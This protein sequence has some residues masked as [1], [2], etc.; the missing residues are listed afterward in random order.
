MYNV[1]WP[2]RECVMEDCSRPTVSSNVIALMLSEHRIASLST[3]LLSSAIELRADRMT[4]MSH[5]LIWTARRL[6]RFNGEPYKHQQRWVD[7]VTSWLAPVD[8]VD[9]FGVG[10]KFKRSEPPRTEPCGTQVNLLLMMSVCCSLY[11]SVCVRPL[12]EDWNQLK[13]VSV[14]LNW[15]DRPCQRLQ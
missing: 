4:H 7:R 15:S 13:A 5:R 2:R 8:H 3:R 1:C 10:C 12:R 14:M 9:V 6:A 11:T